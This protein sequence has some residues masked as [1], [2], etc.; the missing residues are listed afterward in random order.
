MI[1]KNPYIVVFDSIREMSEERYRTRTDNGDGDGD[2]TDNGDD[3]SE[4]QQLRHVLFPVMGRRLDIYVGKSYVF[5]VYP[6]IDENRSSSRRRKKSRFILSIPVVHLDPSISGKY[7]VSMTRTSDDDPDS[8][9]I[10]IKYPRRRRL[11]Y[12]NIN[13]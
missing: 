4:S 9:R 12:E 11:S 10:Y 2:D 5:S 13:R 3:G 8:I 6:F 7:M 1:C